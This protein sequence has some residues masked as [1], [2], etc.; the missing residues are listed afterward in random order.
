MIKLFEEFYSYKG[1]TELTFPKYVHDLKHHVKFDKK[2]LNFLN[3]KADELGYGLEIAEVN[4]SIPG[5]RQLARFKF[6]NKKTNKQY[7][8]LVITKVED[9]Y[10]L[11]NISHPYNMHPKYDRT[12]PKVIYERKYFKCDQ[13]HGL[14]EL[15]DSSKDSIFKKA[16]E[17]ENKLFESVIWV[18][19]AY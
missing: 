13:I 16:D 6:I 7:S 3:R 17:F 12:E 2:D 15:L 8:F 10:Y 14:E 4:D 5:S 19:R 11:V 9:D 18:R 1:Y